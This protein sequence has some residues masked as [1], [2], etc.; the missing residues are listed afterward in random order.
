MYHRLGEPQDEHGGLAVTPQHFA[1]HLA[2]ARALAAPRRLQDVADLRRSPP[3]RR[4]FAVTFDD[5]YADNLHLAKPI[6]EKHGVPAT[7]FVTSGFVGGER[8]FWWDEIEAL[9]GSRGVNVQELRARLRILDPDEL[10]AELAALRGTAGSLAPARPS[11]RALTAEETVSLAEGGLVEIGSHTVRHPVLARLRPAEQR[12]EFL[13]S[14]VALER[15]LGRP[16]RSLAYPFGGMG[17]L[18]RE[19]P[20]LAGACGYRVACANW[21]GT[22]TWGTHPLRLPRFAVRDWS[23]DELARRLSCWLDG[24]RVFDA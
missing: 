23:G 6:L 17:D 13:D 2:V 20:A 19:T 12:A 5:G 21:P 7:V 4:T 11:R 14:R 9:G 22:V 10:E 1:E 15:L 16:V 24:R 18:S 8:E 3:R